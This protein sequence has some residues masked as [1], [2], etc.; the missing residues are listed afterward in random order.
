MNLASSPSG[1]ATGL[2]SFHDAENDYGRSILQKG[3]WVFAVCD[4]TPVESPSKEFKFTSAFVGFTSPTQIGDVQPAQ[5]EMEPEVVTQEQSQERIQVDSSSTPSEHDSQVLAQVQAESASTVGASASTVGASASTVGASLASEPT[6]IDRRGSS[7]TVGSVPAASRSGNSPWVGSC[8]S[9][10]VETMKQWGSSGTMTHSR[11]MSAEAVKYPHLEYTVQT[12]SAY[13]SQQTSPETDFD[14]P[15]SV[16]IVQA[17]HTDSISSGSVADSEYFSAEDDDFSPNVTVRAAKISP[18]SPSPPQ[19]SVSQQ[20]LE[21]P[22]S[23]VSQLSQATIGT[24]ETLSSFSSQTVDSPDKVPSM[25]KPQIKSSSSPSYMSAASSEEA[26]AHMLETKHH[27]GYKENIMK[28][29]STPYRNLVTRTSCEN[30]ITPAP[31]HPPFNAQDSPTAVLNK[32]NIQL[33]QFTLLRQGLCP[34]M[35]SFHGADTLAWETGSEDSDVLLSDNEEELDGRPKSWEE[36]VAFEQ[37]GF[38]GSK[39]GK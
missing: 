26:L 33:P 11:N 38:G 31:V 28:C 12:A 34:D 18:H 9:L 19:S 8:H 25:S 24:A 35:V 27:P 3:Q 13:G 39:F 36:E 17:Y 30:W 14:T 29:N 6:I 2:S 23:P 21:S 7:V 10:P 32:G 16:P 15:D 37:A 20:T 5:V 4:R 22:Q 1:R